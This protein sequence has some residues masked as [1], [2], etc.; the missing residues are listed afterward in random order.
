LCAIVGEVSA[1]DYDLAATGRAIAEPARAAMLLHMMDGQAHCARDL[2]EGTGGCAGSLRCFIA[3]ARPCR[4]RP[5][6]RW[7]IDETY[8]KVDGRW[9]YHLSVPGS[10]PSP[11]RSSTST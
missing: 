7:Y 9:R 11:D 2:A 5:G 10:R 4:H 8:V 3:A 1:A 6:D